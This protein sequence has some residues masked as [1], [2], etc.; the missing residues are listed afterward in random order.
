MNG[1]GVAAAQVRLPTH[2]SAEVSE[3]QVALGLRAS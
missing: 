1:G 3:P 2:S